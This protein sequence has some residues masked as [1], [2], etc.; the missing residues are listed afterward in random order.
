MNSTCWGIVQKPL[1]F[2]H[3]FLIIDLKAIVDSTSEEQIINCLKLIRKMYDVRIIIIAEGYKQG[4][5]LLGKVFNLG[6]YNIV[7]AT[8][9]ILFNEEISLCFSEV[10]MTF[11][12]AM[13]YQIDDNLIVVNQN[14]KM[15][16]DIIMCPGFLT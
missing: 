2:I 3:N 15:I 16:P 5:V 11:G 9:D 1:F 10:G 6:I 4:N 14:N 12:T 8:N 13:K 7:T